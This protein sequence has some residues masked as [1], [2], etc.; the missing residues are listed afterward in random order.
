MN[1]PMT[2]PTSS[3]HPGLSIMDTINMKSKNA[4][5]SARMRYL[6]KVSI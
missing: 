5:E 6:V 4:I 2:H 3:G 1:I